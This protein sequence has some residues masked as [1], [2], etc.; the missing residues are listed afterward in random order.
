MTAQNHPIPETTRVSEMRKGEMEHVTAVVLRP[1]N[2]GGKERKEF[3]T[4]NTGEWVTHIRVFPPGEKPFDVSGHYF[5][6]EGAEDRALLDYEKRVTQ[7]FAGTHPCRLYAHGCVVWW[8]HNALWYA[9][10]MNDGSL[11]ESGEV[12]AAAEASLWND[13]ANML[14]RQVRR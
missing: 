12:E 8:A 4:A 13:A 10:I 2:D 3:P 7:H 6:G 11:S 9:P 1:C 14:K 5:E